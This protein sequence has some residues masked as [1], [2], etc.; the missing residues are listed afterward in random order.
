MNKFPGTSLGSQKD[1]VEMRLRLTFLSWLLRINFELK[2]YKIFF[3]TNL[4]NYWDIL[5]GVGVAEGAG[6]P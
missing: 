4:R 5:S 2:D 6:E 1:I 3:S